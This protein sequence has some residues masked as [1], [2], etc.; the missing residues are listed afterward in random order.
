MGARGKGILVWGMRSH[1]WHRRPKE[2]LKGVTE[3]ASSH[4]S[5]LEGVRMEE[6]GEVQ[7]VSIVIITCRLMSCFEFLPSMISAKVTCNK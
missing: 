3:V 6:A 7:R 2:A 1:L 5:H 4:W